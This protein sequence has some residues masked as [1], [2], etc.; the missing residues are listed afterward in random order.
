MKINKKD[1]TFF[2]LLVAP[3]VLVLLLFS[4]LPMFGIV[5][6]FQNFN[7]SKGFIFSEWVGFEH[8]R[9]L[10]ELPDTMGT[11]RNTIEISLM[12]IVAG[13]VVPVVFALFLNEA[14]IMWFKRT[15]QSLVYLPHF[16][17]WV[18]LGGI[19][20]DVLSING[21]AFNQA[22]QSVGI[23]P[24]FFFGDEFWFR[25]MI[26]VSDVWKEFGFSTIVYLAALTGINPALYEA[27]AIDGATRWK[28]TLYITIPGI[29]PVIV[30]MSTLSL[31]NVLNAGFDQI[32]NLY[33]PMVISSTDIIDTYIY[34]MGLIQAQYGLATAI[35]L[36][37]SV[38]GFVLIV[39]SY[40][41]A[42]RYANYRIF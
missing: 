27:A 41:L 13:L 40:R 35:G 15:V 30:L 12:K 20:V 37:K 34:R 42:S 26:V 4:Y 21:G 33:N 16:L 29:L 17:S 7:P 14:R 24:I 5:I 32:F 8:V 19:L 18:I 36:I 38:I 39:I 11:I 1:L 23:P 2:H 22:L 25:I 3:G 6:A 9:F 10:F 28:R 31:G